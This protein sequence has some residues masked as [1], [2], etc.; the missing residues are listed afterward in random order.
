MLCCHGAF[1]AYRSSL[2]DKLWPDY[3][4]QTYRGVPC[5][6]GDDL[7][8]T[9]LILTA[10]FRTEYAPSARALTVAPAALRP[11]WRQQLRWARSFY[12]ELSW[13]VRAVADRRSLYLWLDVGLHVLTPMVAAVG[14]VLATVELAGALSGVALPRSGWLRGLD[15][16]I[17]GLFGAVVAV[18][19]A[20]PVTRRFLPYAPLYLP[21]RLVAGVW[22]MLTSA[23][24]AWGTRGG[25]AKQ[26]G[27]G[28]ALRVGQAP[29]AGLVGDAELRL[30]DLPQVSV[31]GVEG[32]AGAVQ[33]H[34]VAVAAEED[35]RGGGG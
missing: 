3:Q 14:V 12:R 29:G 35:R 25:S 19:A 4:A 23:D 20:S 30:G 7:H 11:Y 31:G 28:P 17:V 33:D 13:T 21:V 10:G 6:A 1:A 34:E 2:L 5:V 27:H 32:C 16:V 18:A 15:G 9:S 8:L 22:A 24:N 26:R